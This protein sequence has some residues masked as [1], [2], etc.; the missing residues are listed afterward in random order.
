MEELT[1]FLDDHNHIV[2]VSPVQNHYIE[3]FK[4]KAK[5]DCK[6]WLARIRKE[7]NLLYE[8]TKSFGSSVEGK[9]IDILVAE[10]KKLAKFRKYKIKILE[11]RGISLPSRYKHAYHR[12]LKKAIANAHKQVDILHESGQIPDRDL[13]RIKLRIGRTLLRN[14]FIADQE[15]PYVDDSMYSSTLSTIY[16][17]R[18]AVLYKLVKN[19][20]KVVVPIPVGGDCY[21]EFVADAKRIGAE[22]VKA[23][24]G[25]R[26]IEWIRD[27]FFEIKDDNGEKRIYKIAPM[28]EESTVG[29][30]DFLHKLGARHERKVLGLGEGGMLVMGQGFVI[31]SEYLD[32]KSL[33]NLK[34]DQYRVYRLPAVNL[35]FLRRVVRGV[36]P[37]THRIFFE[38]EH[39]DVG[40]NIIPGKKI[41][42]V[43]PFYYEENRSE[44]KRIA[45]REGHKLVVIPKSEAHLAPANFLNLPDGKVLVNKAARLN[46]R[47][48]KHGVKT[49]MMHRKVYKNL[50]L[51]GGI[52]CF[53]NVVTK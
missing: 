28:N 27:L 29:K 11:G 23:D 20:Y 40:I 51:H 26:N 18:L 21:S 43:D 25:L 15:G 41:I 2:L 3:D 42:V 47:L 44:I 50:F 22:I 49:I 45:R 48:R 35:E 4:E 10:L 12:T 6:E 8:K 17:E 30:I 39:I 5:L 16:M 34:L 32:N 14:W 38:F 46:K 24:V 33:K 52:R 37:H 31:V 9:A 13:K 19:G 1:E 36:Q 7:T 53:T